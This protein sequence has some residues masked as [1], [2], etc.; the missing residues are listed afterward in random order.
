MLCARTSAGKKRLPSNRAAPANIYFPITT[1]QKHSSYVVCG[2]RRGKKNRNYCI[3]LPYFMPSKQPSYAKCLFLKLFKL[4][5]DRF[6]SEAKA[7]PDVH[8]L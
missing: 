1:S 7:G 3:F 8:L 2:W 6:R 5:T 4:A